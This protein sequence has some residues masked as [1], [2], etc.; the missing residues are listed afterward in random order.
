MQTK[1]KD[2]LYAKKQMKGLQ[3]HFLRN[4]ASQKTIGEIPLKQR[5][6]GN[7]QARFLYPANISFKN[8]SAIKTFPD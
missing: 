6:A 7:S 1:K 3:R 2:I 5:G 8:R 4:Y